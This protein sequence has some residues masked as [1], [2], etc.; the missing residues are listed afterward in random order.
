MTGPVGS[1]PPTSPAVAGRSAALLR[2]AQALEA[3]FYQQMLQAMRDA[4]PEGGVVETSTGER[5]FREMFDEQMAR[6]AAARSERGLAEALYRQ[7]R[8]HLPPDAGEITTQPGTASSSD[9]LRPTAAD[10][11]P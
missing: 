11:R 5:V 9:A 7:L 8:R 1:P 2:Q 6:Q 4:M 3:V 10:G